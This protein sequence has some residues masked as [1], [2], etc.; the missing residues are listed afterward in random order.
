MTLTDYVKEKV[1][2]AGENPLVESPFGFSK[3]GAFLN[4][5]QISLNLASLYAR[6]GGVFFSSNNPVE[7]YVPATEKGTVPLADD[8]Q[9]YGWIGKINPD[10]AEQAVWWAFEI[11]T[12]SESGRFLREEHPH[13]IFHF[14]EMGRRHELTVRFGKQDW[15]VIDA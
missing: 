8:E 2:R 15:E 12:E 14:F 4:K 11:L 6:S 5:W 10:L 13:V 3:K 1:T 7:I 9:P